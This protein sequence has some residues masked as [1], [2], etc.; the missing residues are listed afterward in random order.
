M[1]KENGRTKRSVNKEMASKKVF[2]CTDPEC[3]KKKEVMNVEFG[4]E[5]LCECGKSMVEYK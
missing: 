3:R 1:F 4:E 5:I 2:I